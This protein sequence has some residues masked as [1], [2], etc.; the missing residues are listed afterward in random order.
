L[1]VGIDLFFEGLCGI[2]NRLTLSNP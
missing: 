2:T 1:F